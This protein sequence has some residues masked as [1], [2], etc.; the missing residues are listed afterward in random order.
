ME[1]EKQPDQMALDDI[2]AALAKGSMPS[3]HLPRVDNNET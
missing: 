1:E 3:I 2:D